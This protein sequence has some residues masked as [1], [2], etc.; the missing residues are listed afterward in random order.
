MHTDYIYY[1]FTVYAHEHGNQLHF[2]RYSRDFNSIQFNS[3]QFYFIFQTS[4]FPVPKVVVYNAHFCRFFSIHPYSIQAVLS[5]QLRSGAAPGCLFR[6][7]KM[8]RYYCASAEMLRASPEN[9]AVVGLG[10]TPTHIFP[11]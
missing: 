4:N 7:G 11:I 6:E 1:A 5:S 2:V 3:I 10:W 8:P 9:F